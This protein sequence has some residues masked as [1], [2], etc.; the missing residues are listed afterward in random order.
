MEEWLFYME[1]NGSNHWCT[2]NIIIHAGVS[3][4]NLITVI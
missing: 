3:L 2:F 1:K 4:I